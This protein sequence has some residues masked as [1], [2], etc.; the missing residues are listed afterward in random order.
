MC[1]R[2]IKITV[3]L[4]LISIGVFGQKSVVTKTI[5]PISFGDFPV[6]LANHVQGGLHSVTDLTNRDAIPDARKKIG[7]L[8]YVENIKSTYK[9]SGT[10]WEQVQLVQVRSARPASPVASEIIYNTTT[11]EYEYY[12]GSDWIRLQNHEPVT[13]GTAN[14]LSVTSSQQLSLNAATTTTAGAMSGAD[15]TKLDAIT[16]LGSGEIITTSE[17]TKLNNISIT[18]A[19]DLDALETSVTDNTSDISSNT[20]AISNNTTAIASKANDSE[21]VKLAGVQTVTGD[22]TFSGTLTITSGTLSSGR[23]LT[24]DASG[25]ASWQVPSSGV[26][27][28]NGDTVRLSSITANNKFLF[29]QNTI[30]NS[31]N[32]FFYDKEV[33][34]FG[35]GSNMSLTATLNSSIIAGSSSTIN[36]GAGSIILAGQ[37]HT[38]DATSFSAILGGSNNSITGSASRSIIFGGSDNS[39]MFSSTI[40]GGVGLN[41]SSIGQTLFGKYNVSNANASFIIGGGADNANR[42]NLLEV[43][44]TGDVIVKGN[45]T[46]TDGNINITNGSASIGNLKLIDTTLTTFTDNDLLI[47]PNLGTATSNKTIIKGFLKIDNPSKGLG[48]IL[49][50]DAEGN[51]TWAALEAD[52]EVAV[53]TISIP[54]FTTDADNATWEVLNLTNVDIETQPNTLS[55]ESGK[56]RVKKTGLYK[57][58]WSL[59]ADAYEGLPNGRVLSN[60]TPITSSE[61]AG[62]RTFYKN[63]NENDLLELQLNDSGGTGQNGEAEN[64][65]LTVVQFNAP[66]V[67]QGVSVDSVYFEND[68]MFVHTDDN[69]TW[70]SDRLTKF[71]DAAALMVG[72]ADSFTYG[73][74]NWRDITLNTQYVENQPTILEYID[75]TQTVQVKETG[76]Y[77]V[78]YSTNLADGRNEVDIEVQ[79]NS[80]VIPES[81]G[82]GAHSFVHEFVANDI[83]SMR[84]R[85]SRNT[86]TTVTKMYLNIVKIL[87]PQ[88]ILGAQPLGT[89]LSTGND[90]GNQQIKNLAAPTDSQDAATKAYVDA[91]IASGG[92]ADSQR[93]ETYSDDS[94]VYTCTGDDTAWYA[95]RMSK[96]TYQVRK[97]IGS[98]SKPTTLSAVQALTY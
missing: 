84:A 14:G 88:D 49:T 32:I 30:T 60:S 94:Y 19:V 45:Y 4:L 66:G 41:S 31:G 77:L 44:N 40:L 57:I 27:I 3:V 65:A 97:H 67:M 72:D 13:L 21:V 56:V 10:N 59:L 87:A 50:S 98:G 79:K 35:S 7:M 28:Q 53:V 22:K 95:E 63:C 68:T 89:I 91:N 33:N 15:K 52:E 18:Q 61:G 80:V 12:N 92:F 5:E 62:S 9:W 48:N 39:T 74:N 54:S 23:V 1:L 17:R 75:G 81:A 29:G 69:K 26:W 55:S 96:T 86:S 90:A 37:N 2:E 47:D 83:V 46:S 8:C 24:S 93:V 38:I 16:T 70:K 25:V 34:N 20:T 82:V 42:E 76:M 36:G 73:N 71:K 43:L 78:T 51:A 11:N 58:T 64:I 85:R 6:V